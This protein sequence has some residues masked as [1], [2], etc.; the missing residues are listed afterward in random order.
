MLPAR[1]RM[2]RQDEFRAALRGGRRAARRTVVVHSCIHSPDVVARESVFRPVDKPVVSA[3]AVEP[4]LVTPSPRVGVVVSKAVGSAVV[5]NRVKRRLRALMAA[6]VPDLG[7]A[8]VVVRATP[9]SATATSADLA[10]DLDSALDAIAVMVGPGRPRSTAGR[11]VP[12]DR[13]ARG[14]TSA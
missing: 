4:A 6:R 3:L 7:A 11:R 13:P 5:R 12:G 2:R 10:A 8:F 14:E 1:A 9:A